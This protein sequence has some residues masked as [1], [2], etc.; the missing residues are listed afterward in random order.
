MPTTAIR[1]RREEYSDATRQALLDAGKQQFLSAGYQNAS[2]EAVVRDARVTRGALYHHFKDK[3]AL[4]EAIV[5]KMQQEINELILERA[6]R[7]NGS[8]EKM[9]A[10]IDRFLDCCLEPAYRQ[11]V[12]LDAPSVLG[13]ARFR[14]IDQEYPQGLL[15]ANIEALA[16]EGMIETSS[17]VILSQILGAC[18]CE[19]SFVVA[20]AENATNAKKE[21]WKIINNITSSFRTSRPTER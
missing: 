16:E 21:A 8:W 6:S 9:N 10:G 14:E 13:S 11:I 17:E 19:V 3:K 15:K 12:I 7:E 5:I 1:G 4:F 18:I 2:I 20:E